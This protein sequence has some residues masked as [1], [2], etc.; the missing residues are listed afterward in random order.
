[1]PVPKAPTAMNRRRAR[2]YAATVPITSEAPVASTVTRRL[3]L[4]QVRNSVSQM[5]LV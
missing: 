5:S 3:F 4:I 1:M 2:A